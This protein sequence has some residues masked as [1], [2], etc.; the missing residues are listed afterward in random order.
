MKIEDH[1]VIEPSFMDFI[2]PS[3]FAKE[4]LYYVTKFGHFYCTSGYDIQREFLDSFLLIYVCHGTLNLETRNQKTEAHENQILLLDCQYA[5]KYYCTTDT[6]FIWFHFNGNS[7]QSYVDYLYEKNG[8]IFDGIRSLKHSFI[9]MLASLQNAVINEHL[10]SANLSSIFSRMA[11]P[12]VNTPPSEHPLHPAISYITRHYA[13]ETD[14]NF[15]AGLC[16][17]SVS[18]F[19]RSFYQYTGHTPHGFLLLFRLRQAKQLLLTS[20]KS[21]EEISELCGFNSASHF[22][23]AFRKQEQIS[24][25]QFRKIPY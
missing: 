15:L 13:E 11:V 6:E 14:L 19:I 12:D 17:L 18:H 4:A 23:R 24:P 21:I 16:G 7:S 8:L 20:S 10:I 5:H 2:V 22:A 3:A 1:G 25:S 9:S